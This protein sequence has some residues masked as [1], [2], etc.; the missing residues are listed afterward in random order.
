MNHLRTELA[1]DNFEFSIGRPKGS[2]ENWLDVLMP[3][4]RLIPKRDKLA[5]TGSR[6]ENL[7]IKTVGSIPYRHAAPHTEIAALY[8]TTKKW[9]HRRQ[10]PSLRQ[11]EEGI[12]SECKRLG[13]IL[14][15]EIQAMRSVLAMRVSLM[16]WTELQRNR[17]LLLGLRSVW[18]HVL[19]WMLLD[20]YGPKV[21]GELVFPGAAKRAQLI[22]RLNDDV[23]LEPIDGFSIPHSVNIKVLLGAIERYW[24]AGRKV[25]SSKPGASH[26]QVLALQ[27]YTHIKML[28]K[29]YHEYQSSTMDQLRAALDQAYVVQLARW[30]GEKGITPP[31]HA[32]DFGVKGPGSSYFA[33]S[34]TLAP[35]DFHLACRIGLL[36]WNTLPNVNAGNLYQ[37]LGKALTGGLTVYETSEDLPYGYCR[38]VTIQR[39][40]IKQGLIEDNCYRMIRAYSER[41]GLKM[42]GKNGPG[43]SQILLP[44][45]LKVR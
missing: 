3:L 38:E 28:V 30:C 21:R 23:R 22:L 40:D 18:H 27:D 10:L 13:G 19:S 26:W 31:T 1:S 17:E 36:V 25:F 6:Y 2:P 14:R 39:A 7:P 37:E 33:N 15:H 5:L 11:K 12:I 4:P 41:H 16:S 35:Q 45:A 32:P 29:E 8:A 24:K 34:D 42:R 20:L 9:A 44:A 43:D